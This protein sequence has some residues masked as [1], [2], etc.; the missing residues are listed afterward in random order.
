MWAWIAAHDHDRYQKG[1][2]ICA[3][4]YKPNEIVGKHHWVWYNFRICQLRSEL[5]PP[6]ADRYIPD[7]VKQCQSL[8][9][10]STSHLQSAGITL[11]SP[12][13]RSSQI[14]DKG[15][16]HG[17]GLPDDFKQ[18]QSRH[19]GM[20]IEEALHGYREEQK[21]KKT[22]QRNEIVRKCSAMSKS[23]TIQSLRLVRWNL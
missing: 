23:Y 11:S 4:I 15:F 2:V 3:Y 22:F 13:F 10:V 7:I 17:N 6:P 9:N 20:T 1:D 21:A 18:W 19:L 8:G 5:T 12:S 16:A 14:Q